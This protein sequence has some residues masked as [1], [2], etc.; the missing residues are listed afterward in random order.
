MRGVLL[1]VFLATC[2]EI[3]NADSNKEGRSF[4]KPYPGKNYFIIYN[5]FLCHQIYGL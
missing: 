5:K 4:F 2:L 3:I 1:V